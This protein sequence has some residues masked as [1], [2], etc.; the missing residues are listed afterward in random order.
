MQTSAAFVCSLALVSAQL[1]PACTL[2]WG[3]APA[4]NGAKLCLG[5]C[6][7]AIWLKILIINCSVPK[8]VLEGCN[9]PVRTRGLT[10]WKPTLF[11]PTGVSVTYT[12]N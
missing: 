10:P 2:C 1:L 5:R 8:P 4:G 11:T 12:K 6:E 3:M 7:P 9:E